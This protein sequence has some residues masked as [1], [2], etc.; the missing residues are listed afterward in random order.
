MSNWRKWQLQQWNEHLVAHYF[1]RRR[2]GDDL[3]VVTLLATP[4]ELTFATRDASAD[5]AEVWNEFAKCVR[6]AI[7][8]KN[9][10]LDHASDYADWPSPVVSPVVV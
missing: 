4:D 6:E 5:P 10:L 8:Y 2:D 3:P 9:S 1:G 7:S